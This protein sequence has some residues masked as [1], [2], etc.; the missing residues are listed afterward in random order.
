MRR[1]MTADA[2]V[3]PSGE[4]PTRRLSGP[5]GRLASALALGLSLYALYWV[6]FIVQPQVYRVSF[7]LIALVLTFLCYPGR[8]RNA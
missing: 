5:P 4:A 3:I 8:R 1:P 7:L 6:L 2:E